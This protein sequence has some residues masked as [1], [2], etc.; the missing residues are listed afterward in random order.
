MRT[1]EVPTAELWEH[2]RRSRSSEIRNTLVSRYMHLVRSTAERV[3]PDLPDI[4]DRDEL[5]GAGALGLMQAI[6]KYDDAH[7]AK[8][9][10]YCSSRIRGAMLDELRNLD[11]MPRPM[12]SKAHRIRKMSSA[13]S[14]TLGRIPTDQEVAKNL[15]LAQKE[16][17]IIA[18]HASAPPSCSLNATRDFDNDELTAIDILEDYRA[19]EPSEILE[20]REVS[21]IVMEVIRSLPSTDRLV[22]L[23][24]YYDRLT[25]KQIGQVL[26]ITESRICQIHTEVIAKL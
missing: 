13:L 12:R 8:F 11:W 14:H 22:I 1:D 10:T 6:E 7:G 25:M 19:P 15:G 17:N 5:L 2:Y 18:M 4:V 16:Y 9:E 26:Q 3:V 20:K 23:L 24:Y 21:Q